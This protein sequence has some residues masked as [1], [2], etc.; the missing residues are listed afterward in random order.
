MIT[1][2]ADTIKSLNWGMVIVTL[3]AGLFIAG[4]FTLVAAANLNSLPLMF[5]GQA[6]MGFGVFVV[7]IP[8]G[9]WVVGMA[10]REHREYLEENENDNSRK[11]KSQTG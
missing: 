8:I 4:V 6:L 5:T 11:E 3:V 10:E 2:T 1:K 9:I 7:F